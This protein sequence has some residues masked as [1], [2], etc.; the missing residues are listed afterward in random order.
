MITS[1]QIADFWRRLRATPYQAR[2]QRAVALFL[3]GFFALPAARAN[4]T[5]TVGYTESFEAY[6]NGF[7][8]AGT[9]GWSAPVA[10]AGVV[11]TNADT[12]YA[13]TNTYRVTSSG[14]YPLSTTHSNVLQVT[15]E[16]TDAI[17]SAPGAV[18]VLD[19]LAM[20]STPQWTPDGNTNWQYAFYLDGVSSNLVVWHQNR[21]GGAP[22]NEWL[23]LTNGPTLATG[24][25]TRFTVVQ[26][27]S[28]SMFQLRANNGAWITNAAGWARTGGT[29]VTPGGSWFYMVGTN[30]AMSVLGIGE[31]VNHF[32]DD[33]VVTN[34]Q[35]TWSTNRVTEGVTN[36]GAIDNTTPLY[37]GLLYDT[38]NGTNTE[39][40]G[41]NKVTF[42]NLP[43]GLTGV[44]VCASATQLAVTVTGM[45]ANHEAGNS[46][47]NVGIRLLSAAF[48]L[49]NAADLSGTAVTNLTVTFH[50]TPRLTYGLG[51]FRES[52]ADDG[53]VVTTNTVTLTNAVFAGTAGDEFVALNRVSV[54]NLPAGLTGSVAYVSATEVAW[55]LVGKAVNN[56]TND[57]IANLTIQFNDTAFSNTPAVSVQ[58]AT[59]T[60]LAIQF[61]QSGEP[62]VL[63]YTASVFTEDAA[64]DGTVPGTTL[65][66]SANA[67]FAGTNYEDYAASGKATVTNVPGGLNLRLVQNDAQTLTLSF[68]GR[69]ANHAAGNTV[70]NLAVTFGDTAFVDGGAAA[71]T[72]S[73]VTNL[74]V[75]FHD[76]PYLTWLG[77]TFTEAAANDGRIATTNTVTLSATGGA[78]FRSGA[79]TAGTQFATSGV[80]AGL[81]CAVTYQDSTHVQVTLTG[82]AVA[83]ASGNN[84][85]FNLQFLDLAFNT[86]AAS[87]ITGSA[88]SLA[89]VFHDQPSLS[90]D[91]TTF[92]EAAANDGSLA[93]T[94][95]VTLSDPNG[96]AAFASGT[97]GAGTQFA[98]SG[99]SA[100]LACAVTRLSSN[101]A[102]VVLTGNAAAH[103]AGDSTNFTLQ[104][105]DG[106][107]TTVMAT[108]IGGSAANMA[109]VFHDQPSLAWDST[110]FTEVAANDGSI[111]TT[112]T[113]TLSGGATFKS[114]AFG[115]GTQY[116]TSGVPA[117]LNCVVTR[118]DA[119][120]VKVSLSGHALAH[121]AGDT[122][123]F[124][125]QFLDGA[126]DTVAASNI[127]GT[128][129]SPVVQFADPAQ[130]TYNRG[131]SFVEASLGTIDNDSPK[132]INLTSDTF[133]GTNGSDF[134]LANKVTV[135]HLPDGLTAAITKDSDTQLS[136]RLN[137]AA[138][139]NDAANDV[140]NLTFQFQD[141]AFSNVAAALVV[142]TLKSD[143][144]INF[145]NDTPF[146]YTVPYE[147][148]FEAYDAGSW[149]T[150]ATNGWSAE[151][152]GSGTVTSET[153]IISG[154]HAYPKLL[155]M[156]N[157]H[158]QTLYVQS[159]LQDEIHSVPGQTVYLDFMMWPTPMTD[160][161]QVSTNQQFAFYV[162]TNDEL[163]LWHQN[164]AGATPTNELRVLTNAPTLDTN[165]W[166]RFTVCQDYSNA[167]F[168]VQVNHGGWIT[169][170]AGRTMPGTNSALGGSWFHMVQ[171]NNCMSRLGV[172]GV[173][174]GYFDDL[175]VLTSLRNPDPRGCVFNFR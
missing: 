168:Q 40:F 59:R 154:E 138:Y 98:T 124:D 52:D 100:G 104:F 83:H 106:A 84:V 33:I 170:A 21:T 144:K 160:T 109:I 20:P 67:H 129:V 110:T 54:T 14:T 77:T 145:V 69:A 47:A 165:R 82:S 9:N 2:L 171:T 94:N 6:T 101:Q 63:T 31:T 90:W 1:R 103:S 167:M 30:A 97:F 118:F 18:V 153:S 114:V 155:V 25:W 17:V 80:P 73:T 35:V 119:A 72:N 65:S 81:T 23:T 87:N 132:T 151:Y 60:N 95:T 32:V 156:T 56:D 113:V 5:N 28:N 86:V 8:V 26:D 27:Y 102:Q 174:S 111:A 134:V 166:A 12:I 158:A 71:V 34:R 116:T 172:A 22:T 163:V 108:N 55:T 161:P 66:L 42:T 139:Y 120:T 4:A 44:A 74:V 13:L 105:L 89:I 148:P 157:S 85:N 3:V 152:P 121:G 11:T 57:N 24:V 10:S 16:M 61:I 164:C 75:Q 146:A 131:D 88:A 78:T 41:T 122:T 175:S 133:T 140:T 149:I 142:G 92:T 68:G 169:D 137:G 50:N 117:G 128:A 143:L 79:Y 126:F 93:T 91:S 125:L 96:V 29:N 135:T 150:V 7:Q 127:T 159:D 45:A 36:N 39:V 173:G 15:D 115:A 62:K 64:N 141:A 99:V 19:L 136:V 130:L 51:T 70:S 37:I 49:G 38:F 46:V 162:S 48:T 107:F 43:A 123:S 76:Q 58:G 112:N 147:E 53:S